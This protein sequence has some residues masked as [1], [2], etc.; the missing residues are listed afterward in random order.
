MK[1]NLTL[2]QKA[3]NND[4]FR[5]IEKV[6]NYLQRFIK[7]LLD[8]GERHDQTKLS[9]PEVELLRSILLS[10]QVLL[11]ELTNIINVFNSLNR[12]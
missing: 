2:E 9:S 8:R 1:E 11:M 10:W 3:C 6:R 5:H 12:R 7:N 4:T